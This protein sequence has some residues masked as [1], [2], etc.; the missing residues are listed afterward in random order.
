MKLQLESTHDIDLIF[1]SISEF[2]ETKI[3]NKML[4]T[5]VQ[6]LKENIN[7]AYFYNLPELN[8]YEIAM[9]DRNN[10]IEAIKAYR[11][12]CK[13]SLSAAKNKVDKYRF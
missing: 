7:Q 10:K 11:D 6:E 5:K 12:R 2:V 9:I 13:C 4:L 1:N 3:C 8:D